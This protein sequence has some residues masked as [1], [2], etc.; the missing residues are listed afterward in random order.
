MA[1]ISGTVYVINTV[2]APP[3]IPQR[4]FDWSAVTK[5]YER[6]QPMGWG[7][8]EEEAISDLLDQLDDGTLQ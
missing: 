4:W 6:G 8:T 3:P 2:Y 7:E 1:K 5:E